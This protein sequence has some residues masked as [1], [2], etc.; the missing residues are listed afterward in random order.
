[1]R[2]THFTEDEIQSYLDLRDMRDKR[3]LSREEARAFREG[4][5]HLET[6]PDCR[7][8]V[9]DYEFLF[10][11]LAVTGLCEVKLSR[12]FARKTTLRIPPFAAACA[13]ATVRFWSSLGAVA[14]LLTACWLLTLNWTVL[15]GN[16]TVAALP[17]ILTLGNWLDIFWT[18]LDVPVVSY[19]AALIPSVHVDWVY[20]YAAAV[21]VLTNPVA[22]LVAVLIGAAPLAW[23]SAEEI[24][25]AEL[26]NRRG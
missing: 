21:D 14:G 4:P 13:R 6:C 15:V 12:G 17:S 20:V 16:V 18:R 23:S 2:L 10:E 26:L 5:E 3:G 7:G 22:I 25:V 8:K 9:H 19:L 11:D 24:I 1:M